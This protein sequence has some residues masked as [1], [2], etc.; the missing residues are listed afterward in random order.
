MPDLSQFF[1]CFPIWQWIIAIA[2]IVSLASILF[3]THEY[4]G[5]NLSPFPPFITGRLRR[6]A[7]SPSLSLPVVQNIGTVQSGQAI[8][9]IE[10]AD[11]AQFIGTQN[12][13][14]QSPSSVI[15][16]PS[17]LG[18]IPPPNV[19]KYIDRGDIES[20]VRKA[21]RDNNLAAIVGGSSPGGAGKTELAIRAAN[22]LRP[23]FDG[24]IWITMTGRE[25]ESCV[26]D[27]ARQVGVEL[28]RQLDLRGRADAVKGRLALMH[29]LVVLDDVHADQTSALDLLIPPPPCATLVTSRLRD[30]ARIPAT[31]M[32]P[33]DRMTPEQ[34]R[35]LLAS[36]LTDARI[37][38]ERDSADKLA[39]R[40]CYNPLALDI[41]ARLISR[42]AQAGVP[43]PIAAFYAR[44][45]DRLKDIAIG[46]GE[47]ES[48]FAC[49]GLSYNDLSR[50]NQSRLYRLA[51]FH[52]TGFSVDATAA[53]WGSTFA[54]THSV[55]ERFVNFSLLKHV[56]AERYRFCDLVDEFAYDKLRASG[57]EN[58][59]RATLS[60]IIFELFR[61][62]RDVR[63]G[64]PQLGLEADNLALCAT[65]AI[66]DKDGHH[67][68]L[69][70]TVPRNWLFNVI[71]DWGAWNHW[72]TKAIEFGVPSEELEADTLKTLG[73][74]Q[75]FD[76][77]FLE[78]LE[79]YSAA[80]ALYER[81][82]GQL[83]E[84]NTYR[85]I[86]EIQFHEG[87]LN[88]ALQSLQKALN[89]YRKFGNSQGQANTLTTIGDV[90]VGRDLRSALGN[91][92]EAFE[93]YKVLGDDLGKAN[94]LRVLGNIQSTLGEVEAALVA[95]DEALRLFRSVNSRLGEAHVYGSLACLEV[96]KGN[97]REGV[98]R[99]EQAVTL[100][101]KIGSRS[102]VAT[103]Y[104]NFASALWNRGEKTKA[105]EY[106]ARAEPLYRAIG[107]PGAD[108][109]KR[110]MD[111]E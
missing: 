4:E 33:L 52:P 75:L 38:A 67:L 74:I 12:I 17:A 109:M 92:Q 54:E 93:I 84:A 42:L 46:E 98:K 22:E 88:E 61:D 8:G 23:Q 78:A 69:L 70:A 111:A 72:L 18:F 44:V 31:A 82:G 96:Q 95:Y 25:I 6:K 66:Q 26:A 108:E 105:R 73:D 86:G 49:I 40:V 27:L 110:I 3:F 48:I 13:Y 45:K 34:A 21:L 71:Q 76:S 68:A 20:N 35:N 63:V 36:T 59:V 51:A 15:P 5:I 83:G 64:G 56:N 30:I 32:Y 79:K 47:R 99:L 91:Y 80:L 39:E 57:E 101:E 104:G 1:L 16:Q 55:L 2:A 102:S 81:V 90:H 97:V 9:S 87:E 89:L 24:V 14:N 19:V 58:T 50:V 77:N 100:H 41:S 62:N 53:L 65:W 37:N 29:V 94:V 103:D 28:P 106:A 10:H 11:R 7:K 60:K 107:H 43:N 85:A